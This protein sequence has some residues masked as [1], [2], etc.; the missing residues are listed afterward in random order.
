[1]ALNVAIGAP[2]LI[3]ARDSQAKRN[4]FENYTLQFPE[5]TRRTL[6]HSWGLRRVRLA[7]LCGIT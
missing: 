4:I 6:W 3:D 1:M 2:T 7:S 5:N